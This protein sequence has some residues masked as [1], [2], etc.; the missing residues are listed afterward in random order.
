MYWIPDDPVFDSYALWDGFV[1]IQKEAAWIFLKDPLNF[2]ILA[3]VFACSVLMS[4]T[5]LT[6]LACSRLYSYKSILHIK[7]G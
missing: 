2:W 4:L 5:A 7:D 3:Q 1:V 6:S